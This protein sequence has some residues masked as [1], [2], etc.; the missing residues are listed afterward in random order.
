MRL[1]FPLP[2]DDGRHEYCIY[3]HAEFDS[4]PQG[5]RESFP[6]QNCQRRGERRIVIDP[7]TSW[8]VADDGEYWH[9]SAGVFVR[10]QDGRFLFVERAVYPVGKLTVPA[11]HVDAGESPERA[12]LRELHEEVG[13]EAPSVE[14]FAT[15]DIIGDSCRRGADAHR[16]H[17]YRAVLDSPHRVRLSGEGKSAHWLTLAEA[18]TRNLTHPVRHVIERHKGS[19]SPGEDTEP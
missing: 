5:G 8:W 2:D 4:P 11:G 1:D 7:A 19:A 17:A 9:E 6:C 10:D 14:H 13:W 3:C 16:W 18:L 15:E 12:A